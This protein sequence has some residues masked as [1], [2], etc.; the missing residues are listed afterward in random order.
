MRQ[1]ARSQYCGLGDVRRSVRV[2]AVALAAAGLSVQAHAASFSWLDPST[3]PAIPVPN[4]SLDPTNG[5][6][7]GVIPTVLQHDS[8]GRIVRIFAPDLVHNSNFGWGGHLRLLGYPSPDTQY[9]LL[10]GIMQHVESQ[11]EAQYDTGLN[12]TRRGSVSTDFDYERSGTARFFGIGN[13]TP[14]AAQ[15]VFTDQRLRMYLRWAW[16]VT[17]VWQLAATL[18]VQ[19]VK[20]GAAHL[21]GIDSITERFP[22]A[23]GLGT[24]H[25]VLERLA[26]VFDTRDSIALP[27]RGMDVTVY[28]GAASRNGAPDGS[29]FT[30]AGVDGRF[31]WSPSRSLTIAA[32]FDLRYMPSVH[33]APFWTLSSI[34]GES[35][36]LGGRQTL[37]GFGDSR[38]YGRNAFVANLEVRRQVAAFNAF[39][40]HLTLQVAPFYDTGRVF[41]HGSTFP[42][43]RL[44]NVLGVGVRGIA[45]PFIVGY[46]DVG[47]GGEGAAVFTGIDYP[48]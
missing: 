9:S 46:L 10:A 11:F 25:E 13:A 28:A 7:L 30:E 34:G 37:R 41:E 32:H 14:F 5:A 29:L 2:A 24:T 4:I 44:H 17:R 31:Y 48:F 40:T 26:V 42:I 19:K 20:V 8:A 15:S 18:I 38:F 36:V 16:N 47:Y 1:P 12:R 22:Q 3:W 39:G 21:S 27:R 35:S 33:G 6:T 43:G 45:A 23:V